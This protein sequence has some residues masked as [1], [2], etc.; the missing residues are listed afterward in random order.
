MD[1]TRPNAFELEAR[2][3]AAKKRLGDIKAIHTEWY[4]MP[5]G[6]GLLYANR[7]MASIEHLTYSAVMYL[8]GEDGPYLREARENLAKSYECR[9]ALANEDEQK[10]WKAQREFSNELQKDANL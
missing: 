4:D 9:N 7:N 2:I 10:R 8:E 6:E 3:M 5:A 1:V